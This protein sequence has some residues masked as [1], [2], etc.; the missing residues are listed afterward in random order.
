MDLQT[1]LIVILV[2]LTI[3]LIGVGI[4]VILI[5]KEFRETIRKA[6]HVLDN[7]GEVTDVVVNPIT[8][9][10]GVITGVTQSVNAVKAISS[11]FERNEK[12]EKEE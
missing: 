12:K 6:N 5:L 2:I 8:S 3:N 7:V 10:A 1:V 4:Y 9:L 11:L